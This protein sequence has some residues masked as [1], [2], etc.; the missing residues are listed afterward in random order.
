MDIILNNFETIVTLLTSVI[1]G[2]VKILFNRNKS[3]KDSLVDKSSKVIYIFVISM[4]ILMNLQI[5]KFAIVSGYWK[6]MNNL[7]LISFIILTSLFI[8][9]YIVINDKMRKN[10]LLVTIWFYI[11]IGIALLILLFYLT[12]GLDAAH[13]LYLSLDNNNT[14]FAHL[15]DDEIQSIEYFSKGENR[16]RVIVNLDDFRFMSY[17]DYGSIIESHT[18]LNTNL[19]FEKHPIKDDYVF[20]M[21]SDF[22]KMNYDMFVNSFIYTNSMYGINSDFIL[23][24]VYLIEVV[25][26]ITIFVYYILYIS[27]LIYTGLIKFRTRKAKIYCNIDES[28]NY[29]L[30][31][32]QML[33][34]YDIYFMKGRVKIIF[35]IDWSKSELVIKDDMLCSY[36]S[37]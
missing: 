2:V 30:S 11:I 6:I 12:V 34:I 14:V 37:M 26:I 17:D 24:N 1:L 9:M 15:N 31:E 28:S 3:Y 22:K 19:L 21:V 20:Y 18:K 35:S 13:K 16:K 33:N 27:N 25:L 8:I 29:I 5:L 32:E 7:L 4:F 10:K 36:G 23:K